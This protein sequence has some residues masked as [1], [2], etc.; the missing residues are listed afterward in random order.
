MVHKGHES[1]MN[2]DARITES[3]TRSPRGNC[4]QKL[5]D[6]P[7]VESGHLSI[8][9]PGHDLQQVL[10]RWRR[11]M[12]RQVVIVY[13][14]TDNVEKLIESQ[15]GRQSLR[16]GRQV[17]ADKRTEVLSTGEVARAVDMFRLTKVR[18]STG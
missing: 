15:S 1:L 9:G 8:Y 6:S 7:E 5:I 11:Y 4:R 18:V 17:T 14:R 12:R 2:A 3:I 16:V 10:S 13:T